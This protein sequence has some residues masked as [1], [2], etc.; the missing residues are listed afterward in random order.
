MD[1]DVVVE[2]IARLA[3]VNAKNHP[4]GHVDWR[5]VMMLRTASKMYDPKDDGESYVTWKALSKTF[6]V[7]Q[8]W[9]YQH[10]QA[11]IRTAVAKNKGQAFDLS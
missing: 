2:D 4:Y 9:L 7:P 8:Q 1:L 11:R 6:N 3:D 10:C 5:K